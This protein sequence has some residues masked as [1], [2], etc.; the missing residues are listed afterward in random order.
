MN[1]YPVKYLQ[2]LNWWCGFDTHSLE[3]IAGDEGVEASTLFRRARPAIKIFIN[4]WLACLRTALMR[5]DGFPGEDMLK[6]QALKQVNT[7]FKFPDP[8]S[9]INFPVLPPDDDLNMQ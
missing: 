7:V 4:V 2:F 3:K 8:N 6:Q 9:P 1:L 5:E